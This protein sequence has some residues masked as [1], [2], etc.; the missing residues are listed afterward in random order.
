MKII[1]MPTSAVTSSA[2]LAIQ[3]VNGS[4]LALI[5]SRV[6]ALVACAASADAAAREHGREF[7]R[8]THRSEA[9]AARIAPAGTRMKVCTASQALST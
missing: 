2:M 4:G 6:L 3:L 8:W 7:E 9:R 1:Q 5:A